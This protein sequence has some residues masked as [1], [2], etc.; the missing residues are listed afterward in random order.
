MGLIQQFLGNSPFPLILEH[1]RKVHECA[2]LLTP[3]T[4]ALLDGD[5]QKIEELH[6]EIARKEHEADDI[7]DAVRKRIYEVHLLSV[8]KHELMKF[9]SYLDNVADSAQDY[10][11]LLLL[12]KTEFPQEL[13]EDYREFVEQVV[14]V[15][16]HLLSLAE[17]LTRLA[18]SAFTGKEA[19]K[20]LEGIDAIGKEE[21]KADRLQ[22]KVARHFYA[23]ED[24]LPVVTL[25]F[26]DKYCMAL[27]E[28][29]NGA[30]KAGKYLRQ[31]IQSH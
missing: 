3:L 5:F 20:V 11:V 7:K 10:A 29:A 9:L 15:S 30:E 16:E 14:Q 23:M 19:E 8:G 1:S 6:N 18:E 2:V 24:E 25:I 27:G 26:L 17:E 4:D 12:R 21:W 31:L 28:V 13:R 22:R